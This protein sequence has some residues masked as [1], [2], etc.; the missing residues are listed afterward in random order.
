MRWLALVL[1]VSACG[2]RT[3]K[4][5][6]EPSAAA[7]AKPA[8][9]IPAPPAPAPTPAPAPPPVPKAPPVPDEPPPGGHDFTPTGKIILS[10][11]AC[12]GD[13]TAPEGF[14]KDLIRQHC[15]V[16]EKTQA[17][18][19]KS[20]VDVAA[21]FFLAHVPA[22]VPKKVVYP[23]AGGDLSTALTVYP[24]ADEITTMS[25]EP[26]GDPRTLEALAKQKSAS[27][28]P[29]VGK[30]APPAPVKPAP[31]AAKQKST[32]V[33]KSDKPERSDDG[34]EDQEP[35]VLE[36][37]PPT[38]EKALRTVEYELRFLYRVNF[39]NTINMI[40]AMRGGLLPTNLIF[41]LSALEIHG[42]EV[43]SLRYFKLDA[44]G[45]LKYLTDE[46]VSSAP[47]PTTGAPDFRNRIF[48]NAE[49]RFKKP[50]GRVQIYRHIQV[51]LDN[52]HLKKDM[53]VIKHLELKGPIAGMTKAAS[54]LMSWDS[55][56]IIR[57]YLIAN[58]QWMVSDATGVPPRH[59]KPKGFVYETYGAFQIPHIQAGN[60][61]AKDWRDEFARQPKR[62]LGFRFG[63]YDG[64]PAHTNHL[65]IMRKPSS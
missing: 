1:I 11:G 12:G 15:E 65:I 53:R 14:R 22:T 30:M 17:Q 58:A 10:V 48:A 50:G 41:S 45:N 23:F 52:D 60:S 8:A 25:L 57:D 33:G 24:D 26:A 6:A 51:N 47:N 54:Y 29:D 49:I 37:G 38:L 21:P 27:P 46:D 63:Y 61:I 9:A 39:S 34:V 20:W 36:K 4:A 35:V 18:Y 32:A 43:I 13:G 59:G 55:F 56:S 64:T 3:D 5:E 31:A 7:P 28:S 19:K 16:I 40:D 42:Y 44:E 2:S 62:K